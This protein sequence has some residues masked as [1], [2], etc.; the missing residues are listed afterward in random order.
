MQK[1]IKILLIIFTLSLFL[2][3]CNDSK[4]D[5]SN[6]LNELKENEIVNYSDWQAV[7][8]KAKGTTVNFYGWGGSE[9]VNNWIDNELSP[10][11]KK[12]Y[13]AYC[14]KFS[15]QI[16]SLSEEELKKAALK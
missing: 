16:S 1:F 14:Q 15:K 8:N 2:V 6:S 7:L 9:L 5:T 12:N 10:Y 3:S 13:D 11:V 4:L